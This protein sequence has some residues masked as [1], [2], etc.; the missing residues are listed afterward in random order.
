MRTTRSPAVMCFSSQMSVKWGGVL[1]RSLVLGNGHL[2]PLPPCRQ[3]DLTDRQTDITE[4][5]TLLHLRSRAVININRSECYGYMSCIGHPKF[6]TI[7]FKTIC[8]YAL[9]F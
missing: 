5:I 9:Q 8:G 3:N 6:L 1:T 4:N 7:H 2:G